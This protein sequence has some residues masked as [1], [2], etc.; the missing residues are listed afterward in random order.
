M[1]N[2]VI[3]KLEKECD[4]LLGKMERLNCFIGSDEYIKGL[5]TYHQELL[6]KQYNYMC[7]YSETLKLRIEDLE[8]KEECTTNPICECGEC[9]ECEYQE[10][11]EMI[12]ENYFTDE[13]KLC[14]TITTIKYK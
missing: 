9:C 5:S 2:N 13:E 10:I 6:V 8:Q 4:E 14:K 12:T 3:E 7:G 11:E 1:N